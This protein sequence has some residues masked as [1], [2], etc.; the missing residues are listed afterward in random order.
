MYSLVGI[1]FN[2]REDLCSITKEF[3]SLWIEINR[4]P[5]KSLV[6]GILYRHPSGNPGDF[7]KYPYSILDK[8]SK[9]KNYVYLWVTLT[10]IC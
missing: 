7:T 3:E 4:Y 5:Y 1:P 6:C 10:L 8:I 9:K 2:I